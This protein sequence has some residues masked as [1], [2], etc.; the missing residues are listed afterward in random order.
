[1]GLVLKHVERTRSG[2]W[3]YRRRV[4]KDIRTVISKREFKRVL[5]DTQREALAVWS[6]YNAQVEREIAEARR[7]LAGGP[8]PRS[9][10][11]KT[12]RELYAE[13]LERVEALRRSIEHEEGEDLLALASDAI[14]ERYPTDRETGEPVGVSDLDRMTV[15]LLRRGADGYA[16]PAS[17]VEDALR[18][19][20]DEKGLHTRS[21]EVRQGIER[22]L[23]RMSDALG[24]PLDK[25]PLSALRRED[26]RR[27]RDHLMGLDRQGG[28]GEK[29]SDESV[30]R[31]LGRIKAVITLGI[32][33]MDLAKEGVTNP[34]DRL[35][36]ARGAAAAPGASVRDKRLPLPPEIIAAMRKRLTGD[37]L[38]IWR[39]LEGTGARGSEICGL[40]PSDLR[41]DGPWPHL[42]VDWHEG[43]RVKTASSLRLIPLVGDAFSAAKEALQSAGDGPYL[44]PR[45]VRERGADAASA[46]IMK[47]LKPLRTD[48][49][50]V[51][52]S[53]RHNV[54]DALRL[55]GVS[56]ADEDAILGHAA[57]STAI[58]HYGSD[59]AMLRATYEALMKALG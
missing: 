37:L 10:P 8:A 28:G 9:A 21:R 1:M 49:R 35:P 52:Y 16:P 31:D 26:A 41:L 34:F 38:L 23:R 54:T 56:T 19:Y 45:Y 25:I 51:V 24:K 27:V 44:F 57:R 48:T 29:L 12:A 6:R 59:K 15:G 33:E 30:A 40:R 39:L 3:Q 46:A 20:I 58:A 18:L 32:R 50:H 43:R 13:A 22:A 17:S 11:S 42:V 47:H 7:S 55:A 2:K 53:L 36:V 5:G 14:L 4:P